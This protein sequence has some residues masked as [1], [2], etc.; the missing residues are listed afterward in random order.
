LWEKL[1][2]LVPEKVSYCDSGWDPIYGLDLTIHSSLITT[3][4]PFV[5]EFNPPSLSLTPHLLEFSLMSG[6]LWEH[7]TREMREGDLPALL[8]DLHHCPYLVWK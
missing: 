2:L 1:K 7:S 3:M 6:Y 5:L 4:K 8:N